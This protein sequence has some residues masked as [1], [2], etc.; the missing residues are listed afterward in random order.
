M[1]ILFFVSIGL[2]IVSVLEVFGVFKD[3]IRSLRVRCGLLAAAVAASVFFLFAVL[4]PASK[5][6]TYLGLS[7]VL[8]WLL[9]G[10]LGSKKRAVTAKAVE[11]S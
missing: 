4:H 3:R 8:A 11:R 6:F 1:T 7:S 9:V 5:V 10:R 2:V